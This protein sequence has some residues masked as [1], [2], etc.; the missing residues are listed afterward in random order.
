MFFELGELKNNED[1]D[2]D[3]EVEVKAEVQE[4]WG[5]KVCNPN[6]QLY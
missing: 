2:S 3:P 5:H 6:C 4:V 1:S